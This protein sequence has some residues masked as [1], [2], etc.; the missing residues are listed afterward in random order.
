MGDKGGAE[1]PVGKKVTLQ[2]A[3]VD[4]RRK[5]I[6]LTL[7]GKTLEGSRSDYQAYLKR[8]RRSAGMSAIAAAFDRLKNS[9]S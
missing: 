3:Q 8:S 9:P 7:E 4:P 1:G 5:R 2:V 6:S